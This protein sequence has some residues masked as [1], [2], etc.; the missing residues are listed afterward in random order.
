VVDVLAQIVAEESHLDVQEQA[1]ESL[2]ALP[3]GEGV[4]LLIKL[5]RT[6]PDAEVRERAVDALGESEDPRARRAL[7]QMVE[8]Q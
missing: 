2:A 6:H 8:R 5:A 7:L 3:G 1:L 4:P